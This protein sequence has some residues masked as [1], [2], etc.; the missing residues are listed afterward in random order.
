MSTTS[1]KRKSY[2]A[3]FKRQVIKFAE[4][5]SN[6]EAERNFHVMENNIR[7]WRKNKEVIG[8][9][10][11]KMKAR[12]FGISPFT[13]VDL[14]LKQWIINER[15][16]FRPVSTLDIAGKAKCLATELKMVGFT[17][18]SSWVR[19]FMK[20]CGLSLRTRTSLAQKLPDDYEEKIQN[21][22]DFC[23]RNQPKNC[24]YMHYG[25]MDEIPM[26]FDIPP[27]KTINE[28]GS[29][30]IVINTTGHEKMNFTL[31]LCVTADGSKLKPMVIFKRKTNI[32]EK[33]T[34]KV[35][36]RYNEKGWMNEEIMCDWLNTVWRSRHQG[37]FNNKSM[38]ILDSMNAHKTTKVL[39]LMARNHV[40][41]AIIPGG[42]T[43]KLQP[44]DISINKPFKSHM[45]QLWRDW[46][47]S[48]N[49][50]YTKTGRMRRASYAQICSW[51][52]IAWNKIT[53]E[54]II[55]GF[56]HPQLI[57]GNAT[58]DPMIED[59]SNDEDMDDHNFCNLSKQSLDVDGNPNFDM[60]IE[61]VDFD[62]L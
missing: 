48:D 46:M 51:V 47:A 4:E 27:N 22:R 55:N 3:A 39:E 8:G 25:N 43:K 6:A 45:R 36:V 32:R 37:F 52:S 28:I 54:T 35:I 56:R 42:L 49:H 5:N 9:M 21:F 38:L 19:R 31:V 44:L 18:S 59:D 24:Q 17:A 34:D 53:T 12:R 13:E 11:S 10:S 1:N 33:V 61:D 16:A 57:P 20:R 23:N 40:I 41:P 30:S 60:E 15:T 7:R 58:S 50:T 29:Q 26:S 62:E 2:T 14:P